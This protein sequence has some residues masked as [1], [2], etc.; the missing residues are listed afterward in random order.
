L[1][2][3]LPYYEYLGETAN[4]NDFFDKI[5]NKIPDFSIEK[6]IKSKIISKLFEEILKQI[7][8]IDI[9]YFK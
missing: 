9:T 2:G 3:K 4:S 1:F 5:E 6:K 7:F 8:I